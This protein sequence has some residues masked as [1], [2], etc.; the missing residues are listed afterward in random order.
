[1]SRIAKFGI[2]I[3]AALALAACSAMTADVAAVK[4]MQAQGSDFNK[5]LFGEYVARA[6]VERAEGD[7]T[8]ANLFLDKARPISTGELVLPEEPGGWKLPPGALD[9]LTPARARLVSVLDRN[10]RGT[11]P[12]LAARAQRLYDCWVEE[13]SENIQPDDIAACRAGFEKAVAQL[14]DGLKPKPVAA[15]APPPPPPPPPAPEP[16]VFTRDVIERFIVYFDFDSTYLTARNLAVVRRAAESV[17]GAKSYSIAVRGHT[18]RAG[19]DA[20]NDKLA[21]ERT[22]AVAK[23]LAAFGIAAGQVKTLDFGERQP[24]VATADG[25]RARS[26]RRVEIMVDSKVE[27][28]IKPPS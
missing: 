15:A 4:G 26:N 21:K 16:L 13:W 25:V 22:D 6:E 20:Y 19:S 18:D 1:M 2:A 23:G 11:M 9:E 28:T 10:G 7:Y 27:V 24:A 12:A 8:H 14:E 5:A 3:A 17:A